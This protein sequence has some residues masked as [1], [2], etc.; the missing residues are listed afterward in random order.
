MLLW[1]LRH[2]SGCCRFPPARPTDWGN[3][4][5]MMQPGIRMD[6][7]FCSPM[8]MTC[9]SP[10]STERNPKNLPPFQDSPLGLAGLQMVHVCAHQC[11]TQVLDRIRCGKSRPTAVILVPCSEAG[12]RL[13][14]NVAAIGHRMVDTSS[15]NP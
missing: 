5:A 3:Y 2:H 14:R 1:R 12:A 13:P 6:S 10:R 4:L 11:L 15:F 9:T 8:A 7:E